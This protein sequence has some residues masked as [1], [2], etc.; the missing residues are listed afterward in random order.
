MEQRSG[1]V[2]RYSML[3]VYHAVLDGGR[4]G[5]CCQPA[6]PGSKEARPRGH[7]GPPCQL[8][9]ESG[10]IRAGGWSVTLYC[11]HAVCWLTGSTAFL[12][13]LTND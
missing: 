3:T 7:F 12:P 5:L 1:G 11:V 4:L 6:Q 9:V 8:R 10:Q 13:L 2:V